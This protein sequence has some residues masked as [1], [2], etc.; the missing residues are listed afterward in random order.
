MT[1]GEHRV[2]TSRLM[3]VACLCEV[4][5]D[6][7][8]QHDDSTA[9]VRGPEPAALYLK[10]K[11]WDGYAQAAR[12]LVER[13]TQLRRW[14]LAEIRIRKGNLR[15]RHY[16]EPLGGYFGRLRIDNVY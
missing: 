9:K 1:R 13:P 2:K 7:G 8:I 11:E 14:E 3:H 6:L 5:A 12:E 10:T 4:T 16:D 15:A